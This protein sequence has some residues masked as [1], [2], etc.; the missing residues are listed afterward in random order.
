M[1]SDLLL[2]HSQKTFYF[3]T[4]EIAF[5]SP[6]SIHFRINQSSISDPI[7]VFVGMDISFRKILTER[8]SIASAVESGDLDL[9]PNGVAP[10]RCVRA[11]GVCGTN[12]ARV[13][14]ASRFIHQD[15]FVRNADLSVSSRAC[16]LEL[17]TS[18]SVASINT[19]GGL[20]EHVQ[21][22]RLPSRLNPPS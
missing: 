20:E 3:V 15:S 19:P 5:A 7:W 1:Y 6:E 4:H 14:P 12:P 8:L 18:F 22:I 11:C 2:L 16:L 21:T 17:W 9:F 13:S 10:I